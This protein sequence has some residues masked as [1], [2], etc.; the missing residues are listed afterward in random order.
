MVLRLADALA[1]PKEAANQ[2]LNAAGFAPVF[3]ALD[4]DAPALAPVRRA[5]DMMLASHDPFPG[6]AIDRHWNVLAANRAAMFLF[7]QGPAASP[8]ATP[9]LIDAFIAAEDAGFIG[10]WDEIADL[11][12]ARLRA[13]AISLGGD[14]ALSKRIE[15]L[16]ARLRAR[17]RNG[18]APDYSRAVIPTIFTIDG[19]QLTLFSTIASFSTV[20]E[21]AASDI[22]IELMFPEDEETRGFFEGLSA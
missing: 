15:L 3:P 16:D 5:V 6:I 19:A 1:M 7:A 8:D 9:N 20:Q 12:L 18:G 4:A 11:T 22:R 17:E 21:V 2:A 13:E 14:D 10:N